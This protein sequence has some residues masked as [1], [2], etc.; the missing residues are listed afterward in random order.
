MT[1]DTKTYN[2][3]TNY[4]TFGAVLSEVNWHEI[5]GAILEGGDLA[6]YEEK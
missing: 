3:W 4:E 1:T 5:A 2:G 6:G